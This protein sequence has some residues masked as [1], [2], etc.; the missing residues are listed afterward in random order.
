MVDETL[1]IDLDI[2]QPIAHIDVPT[3]TIIWANRD[4]LIGAQV[5]VSSSR[6]FSR[7][8]A[9]FRHVSGHPVLI[10]DSY[11]TRKG[12]LT[13][14]NSDNEL[15][16]DRGPC[17]QPIEVNGQE[18]K[19]TITLTRE[20]LK[21]GVPLIWNN[22]L[23]MLFHYRNS[24]TPELPVMHGILGISECIQRAKQSILNLKLDHKSVLI[25][26]PSGTG[27]EL[28]AQALHRESARGDQP[29]ISVNI[30]SI[31]SELVASE[32]FGHKKGAFTGANT[33]TEGYFQKAHNSTLFLDEIGD[34]HDNTQTALLRAIE[35]GE[36]QPVG[37]DKPIT[38]NVR[39]IAATDA[40]LEERIER[41][42]FRLPLLQRLSSYTIKL[43][44][45]ADR[46]EDLGILALEFIRQHQ[47]DF[48]LKYD[49]AATT[50]RCSQIA[51]L[52]YQFCRYNWPGNV[53]QLANLIR[54]TFTDA[55]SSDS[56]VVPRCVQ[57]YI[58]AETPATGLFK[59]KRKPRELKAVD[60]EQALIKHDWY[61]ERAADELGISRSA[62]IKRA[63]DEGICPD[64]QQIST[65][66][67]NAALEQHQHDKQN[68]ARSL[69]ITP[70]VLTRLIN[71]RQIISK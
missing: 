11:L 41:E 3:C 25:N 22:R 65:E 58:D 42:S 43:D 6:Q 47:D 45:L 62:L 54:Q 15:I 71:E 37:A 50:G 24:A 31:S 12:F 26:G 32:L 64:T 20:Q 56:L 34:A 8:F 60:I 49:F 16:I 53:R 69:K 33:D 35:Y 59:R 52:M 17:T 10:D 29:L 68:V 51:Y 2:S 21:S 19:H 55:I 36:V 18:L 14:Y 9:D 39:T 44:P 61:P 4:A 27:K 38:V 46:K 66:A 63:L 48:S 70:K 23:V 67:I 7:G 5:G 28:I 57:D 30:S 13:R 40:D 1:T